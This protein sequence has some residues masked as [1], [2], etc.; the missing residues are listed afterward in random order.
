MKSP[1]RHSTAARPVVALAAT[2]GLLLLAVFLARSPSQSDTAS[3][4]RTDEEALDTV[5]ERLISTAQ[6]GDVDAW[7]NCFA[8]AARSRHESSLEVTGRERFTAGL[9]QRTALL[10]SYVTTNWQIEGLR[11]TVE[12]ERVFAERNVRVKLDLE[13]LNGQWQIIAETPLDE[14]SPEILYGT[15]VVPETPE[16]N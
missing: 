6:A 2:A 11:A 12:L 14:F 5:I 4:N 16:S 10:R 15:P 7:L 13:K 9:R 3:T 8:G 1:D